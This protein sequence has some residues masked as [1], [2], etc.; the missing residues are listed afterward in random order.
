[1]AV[2]A[3]WY[4]KGLEGQYSATTARRVDWVTDTIKVA[5]VTSSY[6]PDQDAHDFYDDV[7]TN[8]LAAGSGYTAGGQ[9]IPATKTAAYDG[10]SNE[11]RLKAG[12]VNTWTFTGTKAFRYGVVYKDTGTA[13]TSPLL[14]YVDFG[15]QSITDTTFTITWDTTSGVLKILAA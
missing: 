10:T 4:G 15:A 3:F 1:M 6:T 5:L 8:D 7:S 13:A 11:L 2:T 9:A 14:G 12:T